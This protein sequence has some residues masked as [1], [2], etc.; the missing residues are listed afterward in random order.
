MN[1]VNLT[2]RITHDLQLKVTQTNKHVMDFQIALRESKDETVFVRCQAWEQSAD[3]LDQYATKGSMVA[4]TGNIKVDKYQDRDGKNVEKFFIRV[5][6]VEILDKRKESLE[7][8][9]KQFGYE[10]NK[11]GHPNNTIESDDLP[12]Y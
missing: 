2:G 8:Q 10:P 5:N 12:F 4:I 7:Q 11:F 6:R 3:Y 1:T 9:N